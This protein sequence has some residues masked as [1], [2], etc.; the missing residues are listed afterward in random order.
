[1]S[2]DVSPEQQIERAK[3]IVSAMTLARSADVNAMSNE[4][5]FA[6]LD[7]IEDE[8]QMVYAGMRVFTGTTVH[9]VRGPLQEMGVEVTHE[10]KLEP[11]VWSRLRA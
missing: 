6:L 2:G 5:T 7:E 11:S 3:E 10:L 8:S 9:L 4:Q 1:M